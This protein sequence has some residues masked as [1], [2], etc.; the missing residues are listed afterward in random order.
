MRT[1]STR[2][3]NTSKG[4][5]LRLGLQFCLGSGQCKLRPTALPNGKRRTT[6]SK[7]QT[8][9]C[10]LECNFRNT[11]PHTTTVHEFNYQTQA[12]K[13]GRGKEDEAKTRT[14]ETS[15]VCVSCS[16]CC[17]SCC[18]VNQLHYHKLL[19]AYVSV[20][21]Q[22]RCTSWRKRG[23]QAERERKGES[24]KL[25]ETNAEKCTRLWLSG[26]QD[27]MMQ[28]WAGPSAESK[29]TRR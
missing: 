9:N 2:N 14:D 21:P 26:K 16:C 11:R 22:S 28:L 1:I 18:N 12:E 23:R 3:W 29:S 17:H 8:A 24:A 13:C 7:L 4:N 19:L 20:L 10:K 25:R 6:N 27:Q 15:S 5:G